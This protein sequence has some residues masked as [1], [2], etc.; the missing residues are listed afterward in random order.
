[1]NQL[2]ESYII[3]VV[4]MTTRDYFNLFIVGMFN[5]MANC[6]I[7]F[8]SYDQ[9]DDLLVLLRKGNRFLSVVGARI[10]PAKCWKCRRRQMEG[11]LSA[12][13]TAL[14]YWR[15]RLCPFGSG[16]QTHST[17][18]KHPVC[19]SIHI[20]QALGS[21]LEHLLSLFNLPANTIFVIL[22]VGLNVKILMNL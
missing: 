8:L 18:P 12:L 7:R 4:V 19:S 2:A 13:F 14:L 21:K 9:I 11:V 15:H 3:V 16:P 22:Y 5:E 6:I 20:D 1:M 10:N 17:Q